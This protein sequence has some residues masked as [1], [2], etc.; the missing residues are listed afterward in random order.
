MGLP[1]RSL[2][3]LGEL[4]DSEGPRSWTTLYV[5]AMGRMATPAV[6]MAITPAG[7]ADT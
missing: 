1:W 6:F 2:A 5:D 7:S 3:S 4:D